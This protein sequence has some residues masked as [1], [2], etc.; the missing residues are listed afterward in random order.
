MY[1]VLHSKLE[2]TKAY[3][4]MTL[5]ESNR[6][7]ERDVVIREA[8]LDRKAECVELRL[9]V[10]TVLVTPQTEEAS[11][12]R[13]RLTREY[14]IQFCTG[15]RI[16][17]GNNKYYVVSRFENRCTN[18]CY[19]RNCAS[20]TLPYGTGIRMKNG[21]PA[22]LDGDFDVLIESG[23]KAIIGAGTMLCQEDSPLC[24]EVRQAVEVTLIFDEQPA[25]FVPQLAD[26]QPVTTTMTTSSVPEP[27]A[28]PV[29]ESVSQPVGR[30]V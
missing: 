29:V 19:H 11:E 5:K 1:S 8:E 23:T 14:P 15:L 3:T 28:Q 7:I 12:E 9:P 30:Q 2:H 17:A 25:V 22:K 21:I 27:V 6:E 16:V 24:L 26:A 4:K 10:G 20:I 18:T 13:I